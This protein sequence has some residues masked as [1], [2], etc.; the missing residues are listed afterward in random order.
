MPNKGAAPQFAYR[1]WGF[2]EQARRQKSPSGKFLVY[3]A[4]D[5]VTV[6]IAIVN[7]GYVGEE[8]RALKAQLEGGQAPVTVTATEETESDTT[9]GAETE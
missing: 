3:I 6:T 2:R 5:Q 4:A 8:L 9:P 7:F 1:K